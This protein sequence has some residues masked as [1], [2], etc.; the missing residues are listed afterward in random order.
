MLGGAIFSFASSGQHSMS[1]M[2]NEMEGYENTETGKQ[3]EAGN[4]VKATIGQIPTL[5][6]E[7]R[8]QF[9]LEL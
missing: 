3:L 7:W 9:L 8:Y 4:R 1:E 6:W 5:I 2:E